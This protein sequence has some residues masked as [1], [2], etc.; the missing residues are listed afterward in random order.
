MP[1]AKKKNQKRQ[2]P[3]KKDTPA[4]S[5]NSDGQIEVT[6]VGSTTE[7]AIDDDSPSEG[8]REG[9]G[10][11][12]TQSS[13]GS[14]AFWAQG[15]VVGTPVKSVRNGAGQHCSALLDWPLDKKGL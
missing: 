4:V 14:L 8:G 10:L 7:S 6:A 5:Q 1:W 15:S 9:D 12:Q 3:K 2:K 13:A 11:G